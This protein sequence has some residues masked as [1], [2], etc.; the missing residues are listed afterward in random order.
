MPAGVVAAEKAVAAPKIHF[1]LA[2]ALEVRRR[3]KAPASAVRDAEPARDAFDIE[4]RAIHGTRRENGRE[5]VRHAG[6]RHR[7]ETAVGRLLNGLGRGENRNSLDRLAARRRRTELEF[8]VGVGEWNRLFSISNFSLQLSPIPKARLAVRTALA[9]LVGADAFLGEKVEKSS[10]RANPV[11]PDAALP[12]R[13]EHHDDRKDGDTGPEQGQR[14]PVD[15][16]RRQEPADS[17]KTRRNQHGDDCKNSPADGLLRLR[18]GQA[19]ADAADLRLR[20]E[21]PVDD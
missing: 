12:D 14:L 13:R 2:E 15:G 4:L 17:A 18:L 3:R 11:A 10:Y 16:I 6:E 19:R 21:D 7:R 9:Y 20:V 5:A 8:R 1:G